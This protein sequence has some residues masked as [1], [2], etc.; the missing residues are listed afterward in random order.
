MS[1]GKKVG[2]PD[3]RCRKENR[4]HLVAELMAFVDDVVGKSAKGCATP[5]Q[6]GALPGVADV[7]TDLLL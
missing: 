2:E 5:E 6:L 7:L 4:E 3:R 1:E